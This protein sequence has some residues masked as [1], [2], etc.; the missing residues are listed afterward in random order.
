MQHFRLSLHIYYSDVVTMFSGCWNWCNYTHNATP[1]TDFA[2]AEAPDLWQWFKLSYI[3][4]VG[5]VFPF[6]IPFPGVLFVLCVF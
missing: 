6:G 1:K 3:K 5:F 2:I 4:K